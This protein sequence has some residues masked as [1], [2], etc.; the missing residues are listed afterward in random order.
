[1]TKIK[2]YTKKDGKTYYWFKAYL[3]TDPFTGEPKYTT[4]RNLESPK[5][6]KALLNELRYEFNQG[7]YR[8]Q[9]NQ[10]YQDVYDLW[11]LQ[12][13][14]TVEESTFVKTKGI[15]KNHILPAIGK[16]KID[17]LNF[18]ICQ[19]AVNK[20]A[21]HLTNFR[22][23]KSY[24]SKVLDFAIKRDFIQTN[25]FSLVEIAHKKKKV[26]FDEDDKQEN[27]YTKEQ[28][29]QFLHCMKQETNVKA[30]VLF[31]LLAFSGMR[32]GEA[33]ALTWKDIDL[34]KN[35]I[36]INKALSRGNNN[37]LYVK[38]TKTGI[39]RVIK[40]YPETVS[41][42]KEWKKLQQKEYLQLG[43]NTSHPKQLVFSN[44][45]NEYLQPTKTRK[46]LEYILNKYDL[47][48]IT[49]HGFRHTHCSLM[50]EAGATIKEVQDRLG[51][52][53]VK[54]TM[55]IYAHVSNEAKDNAVNK[56]ESF[57]T[58]KKN[59][60]SFDHSHLKWDETE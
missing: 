52:S 33:L 2:P 17:K 39:S 47:P 14:R 53:D 38:T 20:W 22:M 30:Y 21:D 60:H 27:F 57:M 51:H 46:W 7:K 42:L 50:F 34:K 11:V 13:E 40:M 32:K 35:E 8:K 5:K 49:T 10:T 26:Q 3:G 36:R 44:E 37:Q 19:K 43:F 4:R 6:A 41:I 18:E 31:H 16:Y 56:L 59:D 55:N 28:L 9:Q 24:A 1:M 29:L 15:F 48:K 25:P 58:S 12:Y 54:T 45:H 23:V